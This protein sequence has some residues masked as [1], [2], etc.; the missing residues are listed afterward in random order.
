MKLSASVLSHSGHPRLPHLPKDGKE[1]PRLEKDSP[2]WMDIQAL[3]ADGKPVNGLP[4][5]G[6]WFE[7]TIP[8]SLLGDQTRTLGL[9][10]IDFY[11]N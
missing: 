4:G 9:A 11:R 1:G 6:G 5:N 10:W 7:M 3:D 8:R 2:Y